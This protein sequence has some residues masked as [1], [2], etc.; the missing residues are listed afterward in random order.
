MLEAPL[1]PVAE[2][3][4]VLELDAPGVLLV[5]LREPPIEPPED[6]PPE[7]EPP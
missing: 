1:V 2:V 4:L 6:E 7:D 3:P 5:P